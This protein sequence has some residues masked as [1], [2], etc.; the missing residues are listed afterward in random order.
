[1]TV[2]ESVANT[3]HACCQLC[4][5]LIA[6]DNRPEERSVLPS[7]THQPYCQPERRTVHTMLAKNMA[8]LEGKATCRLHRMRPPKN[9]H[10]GES[11]RWPNTGRWLLPSS[12]RCYGLSFSDFLWRWHV[13]LSSE[14]IWIRKVSRIIKTSC[15][16]CHNRINMYHSITINL[17]DTA[18]LSHSIYDI[19]RR[20]EKNM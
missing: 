8:I 13:A 4:L 16:A 14:I 18:F 20:W 11:D 5:S 6:A 15:L 2:D 12:M 1:M 17:S 3:V 10:W 7:P 9:R 19:S